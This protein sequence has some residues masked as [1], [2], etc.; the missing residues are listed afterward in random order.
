MKKILFLLIVSSLS[1]GEPKFSPKKKNQGTPSTKVSE[2]Q[3]SEGHGYSNREWI[4]GGGLGLTISPSTFLLS[5]QLE[6]IHSDRL[7]YGP[8]IQMGIESYVL[9]TVSGTARYAFGHHPKVKPS[10][11]GGL[12]L[13]IASSSFASSVG[14]HI[15]MGM[16]LDY[17]IDHEFTLGTMIRANFAPPL[18]TFFLSWP[19]FLARMEF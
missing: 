9:F 18:K 16:G 17:Q 6:Y 7:T 5:P 13:A 10:V 4:M 2:P 14:V 11:E 15:M 19:L 8:L 1:F 3:A 12:G